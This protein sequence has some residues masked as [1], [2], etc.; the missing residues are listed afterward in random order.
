MSGLSGN[1]R[2]L[3]GKDSFFVEERMYIVSTA[4]GNP[5]VVGAAP[6]S[7]WTTRVWLLFVLSR[8]RNSRELTTT[9]AHPTSSLLVNVLNFEELHI[10]LPESA[11]FSPPFFI[12]RRVPPH[13]PLL[14]EDQVR[15]PRRQ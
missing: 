2:P 14:D 10:D 3:G 12:Y 1:V 15:L 8:R 6:D 5:S 11:L 9:D 4:R 7:F 13:L